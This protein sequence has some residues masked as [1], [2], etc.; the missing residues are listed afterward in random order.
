MGGAV[1]QDGWGCGWFYRMVASP[2]FQGRASRFPLTRAFARRDG[3]VLF[4]LV[5]GFVQSQV[6]Y[7][8]VELDI[9]RRL[10][11]GPM[12]PDDLGQALDIPAERMAI[13]LQAGAALNLLR[14]RR[15]GRY[16]LARRGA[17]LMGVPGLAQIIRH[18]GAFYRDLGDPVALIKG[19][20]RTELSESW[21]YVFG[22][23]TAIGPDTAEAFSDLMAQSQILVAQDTL[24]AVDLRGVRRLLDVGGGSGTFL[25]AVGAVRPDT[26]LELFDLPEVAPQATKRFAASGLTG[27]TRI[28]S[29]SFLTDPLPQGADAISLI[30]VCYDHGNETVRGLMS[31][32]FDTLPPG[33]R[34]IISEPMGG[35][36]R[37][38][39][40][41][42]VYFAFYTLAMQ[43]GRTRSAHEIKAFCQNAGFANVRFHRVA[44]PYVTSVVT[45]IKPKI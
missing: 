6:L 39:R 17:A 28:Y 10:Q 23:G 29:G 22:P 1:Q 15:D 40:S 13:L 20:E 43:A 44:R 38:S 7:A 30:R 25:I 45:A 36:T 18:H 26:Q 5:Q 2:A 35:G 42:D 3:A 8:L 32:I 14:R 34:L 9:F 37:P 11:S 19:P 21:P 4:D 31:K 16:G 24:R 33:G 41:V 12:A 27:R